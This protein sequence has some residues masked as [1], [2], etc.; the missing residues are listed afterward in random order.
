MGCVD[1]YLYVRGVRLG[2]S[3]ND[4]AVISCANLEMP[5]HCR[6]VSSV[7][8]FHGTMKP[9]RLLRAFYGQ[10]RYAL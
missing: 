2:V 1:N 6:Y 9:K 5:F 4:M 3:R 10:Q 7:N 8:V